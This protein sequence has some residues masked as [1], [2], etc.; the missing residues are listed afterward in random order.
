[1]ALV[2]GHSVALVSLLQRRAQETTGRMQQWLEEHYQAEMKSIDQLSEVVRYHIESAEHLKNEMVLRGTKFFLMDVCRVEN[3]TA[4]RIIQLECLYQGFHLVSQ[5]GVMPSSGLYKVLGE[6]TSVHIENSKV[7][8]IESL[9]R[10][11]SEHID[12]RRLLLSAALPWPSPS[13]PQLLAV[14][15]GF[16]AVDSDLTGYVSEDQYLQVELWFSDG[17]EDAQG[18]SSEMPSS[19]RLAELRKFFFK[20]FA[21]H[22]SLPSRLHYETMLRY[23]AADPDPREGFIRALSLGLGKQ[24][25]SPSQDQLVQSMTSME[26]EVETSELSADNQEEKALDVSSTSS[27]EQEVSIPAL[28]AV[29]G[30][31]V[32]ETSQ[33]Q[34]ELVQIF[35]E[36]NCGWEDSIPFSVLCQHPAFQALMKKSTQ[37]QLI[38]IHDLLLCCLDGTDEEEQDESDSATSL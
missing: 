16:K 7:P 2:R 8:Y 4:L 1:M 29:I 12:W 15:E 30:R 6:I 18:D 34:E 36:L 21:D 33:S 32:P 19:K 28:L 17:T 5:S 23:F 25:K 14:L 24:V 31:K 22:S 26:E 37:H 35:A 11:K 3:P 27:A 13:V 38:D 10:D 9:L 20:L